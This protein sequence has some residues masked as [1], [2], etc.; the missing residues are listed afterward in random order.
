MKVSGRPRPLD[1]QREL[2]S[3]YRETRFIPKTPK[4]AQANLRDFSEV[5]LQS[6]RFS[7]SSPREGH[8]IAVHADDVVRNRHDN[9]QSHGEE[10]SSACIRKNCSSH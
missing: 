6:R 2:C 8:C 9:E 10:R 7:Y 5:L 1:T 3:I 4:G